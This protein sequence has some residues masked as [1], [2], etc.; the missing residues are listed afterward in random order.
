MRQEAGRLYRTIWRWHFYAGLFVVPFILLL[1]LTGA[2]YLFKPQLDAWQERDW[3][4]LPVAGAVTPDAQLKA[5]LA[6]VPGATFHNFRLPAAPGDAAVIHVGLAEGGMRD[7][8]VS[9]QGKVIAIDDPEARI[10]ATVSRIHGSL[11]LGRWGGFLVEI[12]A[13]WAILL[14]LSGLYLWWPR[15]RGLAGVLW[16]RLNARGRILW[17]DLH[18]V[19]GFWVSGLALVLLVSGL[20]WTDGWATAFRAVRA[21]LGLVQGPQQWKGGV[22]LHAEHDHAAMLG[23]A[24]AAPP[25][26]GQTLTQ[27][28]ARAQ[29]EGVPAPAILSPPGAPARFGPPNG[30]V[31]KVSSETQNRPIARSVSFDPVTG[32]VVS[33][34]GFADK[35][36]IDRAI[37]YGIAWHEGQLFGW[38]NQL[39]GVATAAALI[40]LGVSGTVMWWRR[41][42]GGSLGAPPHPGAARLRGVAAITL[43]AAALLPMLALSL[44][45]VLLFDRL[46]LR[47]W[48]RATQWL[49]R[50]RPA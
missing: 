22:D 34:S 28:V 1:A 45:A 23:A 2:I 17:R 25:V 5:A 19:T 16:P 24:A 31:W 50:T 47:H 4:G 8:A 18:A 30:N 10:A 6:A 21:E 37:G 11:L 9:P 29:A 14:I 36:P 39:V 41:R 26:T 20:P 44:I 13:S 27:M 46:I 12:A 38:I 32:D 7:I 49:N 40:L 43:I 42:P 48:P 33:R 3:R 35:H 15:G